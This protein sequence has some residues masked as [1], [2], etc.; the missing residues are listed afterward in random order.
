M[1]PLSV[2]SYNIRGLTSRERRMRTRLFIEGLR[3][4][5]D[6]VVLQEHKLWLGKTACIRKEVWAAVHWICAPAMEGAHSLRNDRVEAGR[7][8][9]AIGLHLDLHPFLVS[10]GS[11]PCQ[12]AVWA[13]L[14]HPTWGKL[15]FVGLYGPNDPAGRI[16]LWSE[17]SATLDLSYRWLFLGDFNMI[18]LAADHVGGDGQVIRGR[19][20]RAWANLVRTFN[21]ID[22]Y[23]FQPG[24]LR[25]SWDNQRLHR[26]NPMNINGRQ[27]GARNLR[28][29]DRI[30]ALRL[31]RNFNLSIS[32]TILPGFA[33]SDHA[34]VLATIK[35]SERQDRPS[36]HR[37]NSSHLF[38]PAYKERMRLLLE[39]YLAMGLQ[40]NWEPELTLSR[41]LKGARKADRCW[42]KRRAK[43]KKERQLLLQARVHR[44]Q[45]ELEAQPDSPT[46]QQALME[47][48]SMLQALDKGL[49]SWVDQVIQARWAADGDRCTKI[50][51]KSFKSLAYTKHI[52]SLLDQNG[53][54]QTSLEEMAA[55]IEGLFHTT[56]GGQED[57]ATQNSQ[58]KHQNDV[59]AHVEDR[60]TEEEKISL[61]API[62]LGELE[63][64]VL[65]MKKHKCP[66]PDGAPVKFFQQ[67]W[68]FIG[69][70]I[71]QVINRGIQREQFQADFTLGLIVLLPKKQ[72][73]RLLTNKRPIT[74]LNAIYK[75]G[76]KV[77]QRRLTPILQR[78]IA[79][80]QFAFLPGRNIHHSLIL[81]GEMLHKA[82]DSGEEY[83][84]LK[85]D[86]IKAFDRLNWSYLL[87]L[88][89]KNGMSGILSKF[90]KAG[91]AEASSTVLLNGRMTN[92]IP[93]T[94]SVR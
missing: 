27:F 77:M 82:A 13:C 25:F 85:M 45:L 53:T 92:R 68:P 87:A 88:L 6:V 43:E 84:L 54:E 10:E 90:V 75:V 22:T 34:P 16:A 18:E 70:L 66:G 3:T 74:L 21:L 52:H 60:L 73:Q 81:L 93:L 80:Q 71:L 15:G 91:F 28:R 37:M 12:R 33:L 63:E 1:K 39:H 65:V 9:V 29:L 30:Y 26:H 57:A 14:N 51:F 41:C 36:R 67:L 89:D 8:G 7:D 20:A 94:R 64:A 47:A 19:E 42:G 62:T 83:V 61:N 59:L 49:A 38:Q 76:A 24:H 58:L 31:S 78:I 11:V 48:K 17:L 32:S 40:R 50:F 4:R 55:V 69:P 23:V 79:P 44:A 56:L 86:V 35:T 46:L 2:L 5:P 72:D